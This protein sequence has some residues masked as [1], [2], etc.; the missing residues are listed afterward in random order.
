MEHFLFGAEWR[1]IATAP[2]NLFL[3]MQHAGRFLSL[4][5]WRLLDQRARPLNRTCT[6]V[7][8]V[9][10][11]AFDLSRRQVGGTRRALMRLQELTRIF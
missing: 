11:A 8:V 3:L 1:E 6:D 10:A 7:V 4:M 5:Q 9:S 2:T